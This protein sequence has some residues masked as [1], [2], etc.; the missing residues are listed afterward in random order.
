MN[1]KKIPFQVR[2]LAVLNLLYSFGIYLTLPVLALYF[3]HDLEISIGYVGILLGIPPIISALFGSLG[4]VISHKVGEVYSLLIGII[5]TIVCYTLYLITTNFFLLLIVSILN[6][7]SL[8]LWKPIIKALFAHHGMRLK[9]E[10]MVFRINYIVI[11]VGAILGPVI[12]MAISQYPKQINL[13]LSMI[14]FGIIMVVLFAKK[15][16]VEVDKTLLTRKTKPSFLSNVKRVDPIL[17]YYVLAGALVFLVFSQFETIFSLALQEV[18]DDPIRLFSFL[19]IVN[20]VAGI[21]LQVFIMKFNQKKNTKLTLT[22]GHIA[23][24][25]SFLL[26]AFSNGN[27]VFLVIA[28]LLFSLGEVLAIPGSDIIINEIA[29]KENKTLYFS[30][31]EFRIIG[32]SLGPILSGFILDSFG[33]MMM[34]LTSVALICIAGFIYFLPSVFSTSM[35]KK[36]AS[37]QS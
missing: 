15:S 3:H 6:G 23:F 11:C 37:K 12:A 36:T 4:A 35:V 25:V 18:S 16:A 29:T 7:I 26:F 13:F 27:L 32:F 22:A 9:N 1:V 20:S 5:T 28:T 2:L 8:I 34:F 33:S 14:C 21:V 19:L 10:D 17:F 24:A 30:I 31:A